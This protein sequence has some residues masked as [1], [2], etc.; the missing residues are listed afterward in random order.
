MTRS[1][2]RPSVDPFQEMDRLLGALDGSNAFVPRAD[3][4]EVDGAYLLTLDLPGVARDALRVHYDDGTLTVSGER[5]MADVHRDARLHRVERRY[6]RFSRQFALGTAI[7]PDAIDASLDD[8]VLTVRVPHAEVRKPRQ[9]RVGSNPSRGASSNGASSNGTSAGATSV[10]GTRDAEA[11]D[12][13]VQDA[14]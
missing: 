10:S 8:G 12:V 1:L 6:G 7:D 9:I 11:T 2:S 3:V 5:A 13:E 14:A 4:A